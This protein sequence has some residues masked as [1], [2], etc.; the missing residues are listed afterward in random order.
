MADLAPGDRIEA[1]FDRPLEKYSVH[2]PIA[3][4]KRRGTIL[5]IDS[6]R[7]AVIRFDAD[8]ATSRPELVCRLNLD[9][10]AIQIRPLHQIK[11]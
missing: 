10:D 9:Q 1:T 4:E 8:P 2:S 11:E 5:L 6:L 3:G 7:M